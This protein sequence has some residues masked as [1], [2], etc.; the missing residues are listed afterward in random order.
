[1]ALLRFLFFTILILYLLKLVFRILI[2]VLFRLLVNK[3]ANPQPR[4]GQQKRRAPDGSLNIDFIPP[5]DKEA[6]AADKAGE[7]IDYEEV[8]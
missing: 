7:F 4:R 8:K 5:K 6:R 3:A 2:P 1:M